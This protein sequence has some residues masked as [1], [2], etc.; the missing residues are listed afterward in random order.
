MGWRLLPIRASGPRQLRHAFLPSACPPPDLFCFYF[1]KD[2][3]ASSMFPA[4]AARD[5]AAAEAGIDST[6]SLA[7]CR[8]HCLLPHAAPNSFWQISKV[9]IDVKQ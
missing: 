9:R 7:R 6:S 1:Y 4:C 2:T 8:N 5:H 3:R